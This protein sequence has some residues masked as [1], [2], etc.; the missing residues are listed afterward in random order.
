MFDKL[1]KFLRAN[2]FGYL[3][4]Y[5]LKSR[6]EDLP[7]DTRLDLM[8]NKY[9]YYATEV[10]PVAH[11]PCRFYLFNEDYLEKIPQFETINFDADETGDFSPAEMSLTISGTNRYTLLK[12]LKIIQ[13]IQRYQAVNTVMLNLKWR[14]TEIFNF[15]IKM[16][17]LDNYALHDQ[18]EK[19]FLN[20]IKFNEN[21]SY[22]QLSDCDFSK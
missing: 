14:W 7:N 15:W 18:I 8:H 4:E 10:D 21:T 9:F 22:L 11:I 2:H 19:L 20:T 5:F 17:N 1:S 6:G 16:F 12:T 3:S 13:E